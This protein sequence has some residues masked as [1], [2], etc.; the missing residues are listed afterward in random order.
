MRSGKT[1]GG[2]GKV[3]GG[4]EGVRFRVSAKREQRILISEVGNR[5]RPIGLDFGAAKDAEVEI[6]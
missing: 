2:R 3:E 6:E 1:E 4:D 5:R